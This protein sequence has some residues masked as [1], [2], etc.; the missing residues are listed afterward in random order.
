L[1][2]LETILGAE[3]CILWRRCSWDIGNRTTGHYCSL[4]GRIYM[5]AS[6]VRYFLI[7][8]MFMSWRYVLWQSENVWLFILRVESLT[9][10]RFLALALQ[11]ITEERVER[12]FSGTLCCCLKDDITKTRFYHHLTWVS[13][14][15]DIQT[16]ISSMQFST[17]LH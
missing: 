9:T 6:Y 10:P 12:D 7:S 1:L 4:N 13:L 17:K 15:W 16:L 5:H 8:P 11:E 2:C 14:F 3:F